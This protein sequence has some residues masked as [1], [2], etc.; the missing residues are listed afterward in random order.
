MA[1]NKLGALA[2]SSESDES[3]SEENIN[4]NKTHQDAS[5]R[6]TARGKKTL[7]HKMS[8]KQIED[9]YKVRI[10]DYVNPDDEVTQDTLFKVLNS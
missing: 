7:I 8:V 1:S 10:F 3:T 9:A 5:S 6:M 2:L 4:F